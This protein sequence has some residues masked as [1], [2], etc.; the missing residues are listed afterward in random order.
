MSD[1]KVAKW[2]QRGEVY[3][4]RYRG[5]S[6]Y[7]GWNFS[8]DQEGCASLREVLD[9]MISSPYSSKAI[10]RIARPTA[11]VLAAVK[12]PDHWSSATELQ[13]SHPKF[14]VEAS[15]WSLTSKDGQ[16]AVTIGVSGLKEIRE[17]VNDVS[18]GQGD[19]AAPND[20]EEIEDSQL[21]YFWPLVWRRLPT[22]KTTGLSPRCT[23][24]K[25]RE[26]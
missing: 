24:S 1:P 19:W 18:Q 16:V 23:P 8:A 9:L 5:A 6:N 25:Q 3:C 22:K 2:K 12:G 20:D 21:I 26:K 4:W 17:G 11:S 13:L 7:P 15:H 10:I 14:T